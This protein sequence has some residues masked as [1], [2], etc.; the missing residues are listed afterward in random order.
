[1]SSLSFLGDETSYLNIPNTNDINF[2]QGDF[3]VEWY[4]YQTDLNPYPRIFQVGVF[5]RGGTSIGVSIEAALGGAFYYWTPGSSTN[6]GNQIQNYMNQW[7]H[8]AICR[9]NGVT[10]IYMNGVSIYFMNDTSDFN[11]SYDLTISNESIPSDGAAFGGYLT[12]FSYVKGVARYTNNFTVSNTYPPV[13]SNTV[14]LLKAGGFEG[15]LGNTVVNSNVSTVQNVPP[16]FVSTSTPTVPR[17]MKP[18]YSDNSLVFY[19]PGSSS[20]CGVG[21]VRNSSVKSRRI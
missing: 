17:V 15:S 3:T 20:S 1:M 2:G 11:S 16:G 19:K 4:Q 18:A 14:L 12:Y 21:T 7:V 10:N 13:T 5:N 9:L 6:Y 8:F